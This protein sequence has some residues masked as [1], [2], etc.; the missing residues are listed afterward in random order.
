MIHLLLPTSG[1]WYVC[2]QILLWLI[3]STAAVTGIFVSVY[4]VVIHD[5]FKKNHMQPVE[6]SDAI[7]KYAP[8]EYFCS[9]LFF[10][11]LQLGTTAPFWFYILVTPLAVY[12]LVRISKKDYKLYFITKDEYQKDYERMK[13]QYEVKAVFY[14]LIIVI[15]VVYSVLWIKEFLL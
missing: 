11:S 6:L 13:R 7:N 14:A 10:L 1:F 9:F 15:S 3:K 4:M 2:L 12:N 5:D 8:I